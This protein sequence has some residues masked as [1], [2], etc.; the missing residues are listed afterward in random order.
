MRLKD[1]VIF[2]PSPHGMIRDGATCK[3]L[4]AMRDGC[5][6]ESVVIPMKRYKSLCVS[7]QV[8]CAMGCRFCQTARM[9]FVRDL[10]AEEI[11][12]QVSSAR[13]HLKENVRNVVFMGMGE[14]LANLDNVL[15]A[16]R[17]LND[18]RGANI[19]Q[20]N[21]MISTMGHVPGLMR[22]AG[23]AKDIPPKG[24]SN[25]RIA[26]SINAPNDELRTRLMPRNTMWPMAE[27]KRALLAYPRSRKDTKFIIEYVLI[28]GVNDRPEHARELCGYLS[29][30][31]AEVNLIPFNPITDVSWTAPTVGA[32]EEFWRT[33]REAGMPCR[34]RWPKGVRAM[35]ACGQLGVCGLVDR[36]K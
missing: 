30:I 5:V 8:G 22:L 11:V 24:F 25:L 17:M 31:P 21:I 26:V 7:S 18:G 9:G 20:T 2:I 19:P 23:F 3:F 27:I 36:K 4:L 16:V 33:V 34:T 12:S 1:D 13:I 29:G 35:A 10:T 32:A 6:V 15:D 14:P 28:A